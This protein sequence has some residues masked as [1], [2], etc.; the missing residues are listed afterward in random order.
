MLRRMELYR[1]LGYITF[2]IPFAFGS[3]YE[4]IHLI[5]LLEDEIF[6]FTICDIIVVVIN[7]LWENA[8]AYGKRR[9]FFFP[10]H[11]FLAFCFY[12][13]SVQGLLLYVWA[14]RC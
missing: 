13:M 9:A 7:F 6:T 3:K 4:E 12:A 11:F 2:F 5:I 1:L 10:G 14:R 8:N